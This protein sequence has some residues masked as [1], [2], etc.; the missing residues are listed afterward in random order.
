MKE[1][2]EKILSEFKLGK[3]DVEKIHW[4]YDQL[5][6]DFILDFDESLIVLMKELVSLEKELWY[7]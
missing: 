7:A 5:L 4:E 1:R 6:E 2:I 3:Y